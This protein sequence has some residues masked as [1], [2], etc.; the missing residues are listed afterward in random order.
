ML[1]LFCTNLVYAVQAESQDTTKKNAETGNNV[2]DSLP[3]PQV[4]K[5]VRGPMTSSNDYLSKRYLP[6][7]SSGMLCLVIVVLVIKMMSQ[8]KELNKS[9]YERGKLESKLR[10]SQEKAGELLKKMKEI[11]D[12]QSSFVALKND[13][14]SLSHIYKPVEIIKKDEIHLISEE[15]SNPIELE[16]ENILPKINELKTLY[17][18]NPNNDGNFKNSEGKAVFIDGVSIYKFILQNENNALVEFCDDK[19]SVSIALNN[20]NEMILSLATESNAYNQNAT[21]IVI[22]DNKKAKAQLE[23]NIW[24][25]KEKAKIKYV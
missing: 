14:E 4:A 3:P 13:T 6:V 16:V 5:P 2:N 11:T 22:I 1:L 21:Q 8:N 25:I 10:E 24:V 7:Y 23:G 17:F 12:N 9:E 20:R 15:I 18:P 19:Y